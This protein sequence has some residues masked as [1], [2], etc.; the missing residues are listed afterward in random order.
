V[1]GGSNLDWFVGQWLKVAGAVVGV[2]GLF[3]LLVVV[4]VKALS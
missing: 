3:A 4:L 2:I 1:M